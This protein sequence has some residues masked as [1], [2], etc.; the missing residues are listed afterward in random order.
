MEERLIGPN[1]A[2]IR[3]AA[4]EQDNY[5]VALDWAL[6]GAEPEAALNLARPLAFLLGHRGRIREAREWLERALAL[7]GGP[8]VPRGEALWMLGFQLWKWGDTEGGKVVAT[9]ILGEE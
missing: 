3:W 7:P 6:A 8:P 4:T 9:E 2:V 5:R 1:P